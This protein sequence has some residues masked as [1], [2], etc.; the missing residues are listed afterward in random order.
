MAIEAQ[1]LAYCKDDV[2]GRDRTIEKKNAGVKA[3]AFRRLI[4]HSVYDQ[5]QF[6]RFDRFR[7]VHV[8]A[9]R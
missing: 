7:D 1:A 8:I 9:R 5:R 2:A 6:G 3:E 4:E